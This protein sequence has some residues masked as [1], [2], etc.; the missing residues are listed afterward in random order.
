[1]SLWEEKNLEDWRIGQ[2]ETNE[3]GYIYSIPNLI[4][5]FG[6]VFQKTRGDNTMKFW[7]DEKEM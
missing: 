6:D 3:V 7:P 1:M 5:P 2:N 4:I